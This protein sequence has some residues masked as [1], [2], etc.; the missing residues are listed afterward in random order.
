MSQRNVT[1]PVKKAMDHGAA[2]PVGITTSPK[3][4]IITHRKKK[5]LIRS[6]VE[7]KKNSNSGIIMSLS[8]L[9]NKLRQYIYICICIYLSRLMNKLG[10]NIY[11]YIYI[12]IYVYTYIYTYTNVYICQD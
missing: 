1:K 12:C 2:C 4:E 8:G 3:L 5:T 10:Q 9:I 11:V 6:T 7:I